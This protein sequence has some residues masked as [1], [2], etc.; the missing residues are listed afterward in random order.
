MVVERHLER[1]DVILHAAPH[2]LRDDLH[3]PHRQCHCEVVL[4]VPN[5]AVSEQVAESFLRFA[6]REV[7]ELAVEAVLEQLD[8][9]HVLQIPLEQSSNTITFAR[10]N[11]GHIFGYSFGHDLQLSRQSRFRY[12]SRR[13]VIAKQVMIAVVSIV[14]ELQ[15]PFRRSS[16]RVTPL[17]FRNC[18]PRLIISLGVLRHPV[19][20]SLHEPFH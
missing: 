20:I 9:Y 16:S 5:S 3:D 17:G 12:Q 19:S 11:G 4:S 13:D 18:G 7:H 14:Q 15:L 2:E 1:V 8:L 6:S 10:Y